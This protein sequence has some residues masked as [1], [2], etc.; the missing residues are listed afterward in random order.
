MDGSNKNTTLEF[1]TSCGGVI[2]N[3]DGNLVCTGPTGNF[4]RTCRDTSV[5]GNKV[6]S[7]C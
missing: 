3:V 7:T 5:T 6:S 2:N 1:A 4:A